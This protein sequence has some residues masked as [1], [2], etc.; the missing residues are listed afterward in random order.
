MIEPAKISQLNRALTRILSLPVGRCTFRE[1]QNV[2]LT[3]VEGKGDL[4]NALLETL[5][6]G[7]LNSE[8]AKEFPKEEMKKTID[9]HSIAIWVAKDV[10]EKGD[11]ISLVTSDAVNAPGHHV[12]SNRLKRVDGA[13][14]HFVSDVESTLQVFLH[15]AGRVQELSKI[16]GAQKIL[17]GFKKELASAKAKIEAAI[18]S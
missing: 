4:A 9:T 18:Q 3:T 1:I 6:T 16:D 5:L 10:F 12:F 2:I 7:D 17:S 13:E 14:F 8:K 11:F 15:F